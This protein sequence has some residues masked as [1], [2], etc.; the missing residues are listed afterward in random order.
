MRMFAP[1]AV[2]LAIL[3]TPCRA[4]EFDF[5]RI[6]GVERCVRSH[7]VKVGVIFNA[8]HDRKGK[9]LSAEAASRQARDRTIA[10]ARAYQEA[11]GHPDHFV[12]QTWH[13]YPDRTGPEDDPLTV[14]GV[15]RDMVRGLPKR[16]D[17]LSD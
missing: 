14:L 1:L 3:L 15:A 6:H 9:D 11:G 2:R 7:G 12:L 8:F 10:A 4:R 16:A 13:P 5:G 17:T